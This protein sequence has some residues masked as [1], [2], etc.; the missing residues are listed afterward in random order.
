MEQ[1][2]AIVRGR[3][4]GVGFRFGTVAIGRE[5]GLAGYARNLEDGSV[6]VVAG[7]AESG[8][9]R[10]LAFLH[11]GPPSARVEAVEVDWRD[12]TPA[13]EDFRVRA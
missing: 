11:D 1:F 8:L 3:V 6:E 9:R 7:G 13:G 5:L 2:R 12:R 4:Q 10:L